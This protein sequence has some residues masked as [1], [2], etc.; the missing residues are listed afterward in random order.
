MPHDQVKG[1]KYEKGAKFMA[2]VFKKTSPRN[3][4]ADFCL[5]LTRQNYVIRLRLAAREAGRPTV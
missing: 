2:T 5:S 1:R 3:L 4:P